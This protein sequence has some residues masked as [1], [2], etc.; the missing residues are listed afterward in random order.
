MDKIIKKIFAFD[1][2]GTLV[3]RDGN[4]DSYTKN[5]LSSLTPPEHYPILVSARP[6]RNLLNLSYMLWG[7]EQIIIAYN[8]AVIAENGSIL[9]DFPL[10]TSV[11]EK[12]IYYGRKNQCEL[13]VYCGADWFVESFGPLLE[14][15]SKIVGFLP[16]VL[17]SLDEI[18]SRRVHKVLV[19]GDAVN[20]NHL[21]KTIH[22]ENIP[23]NACF[24]KYNY[25]EIV[26]EGV[27]KASAIS[28]VCKH[29][30]IPFNE[31]I[32]FGD[33]ENDLEMISKAGIGVAMDN[34][35]KSV[36]DIADFIT[37][38]NENGGVGKALKRLGY[39]G[40]I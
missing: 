7:N 26:S 3:N 34:A 6:L 11:V 25:G 13:G 36:K 22:S 29:L 32:A 12:L 40:E 37:D 1:V 15:E 2:D 31:V 39:V 24:S 20:I 28:L 17:P 9:I 27:S 30:G 21:F 10:S 19:L 33:G 16:I 14:E 4:I 5:I 38:S 23:V 18:V 35:V 8:G